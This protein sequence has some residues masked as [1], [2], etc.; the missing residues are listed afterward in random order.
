MSSCCATKRSSR[1]APSAD[2]EEWLS[3]R[4]VRLVV[5]DHRLTPVLRAAEVADAAVL[6]LTDRRRPRQSQCRPR[7]VR[8]QPDIRLVIRMFDQELGAHIPDLFPD[9]V[10]LSS[11]ALARR[12]SC[13]PP[14]MARPAAVSSWPAGCSASRRSADP[15]QARPFPCR[16]PGCTPTGPSRCSPTPAATEPDLILIDVA[17]EDAAIASPRPIPALRLDPPRRA[18]AAGGP[19]SGHAFA[20]PERRLVRFA[21][22]L[23]GLAIRLGD[24]LRR[25]SSISRRSMRSPMRSRS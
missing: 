25:R 3:D 15:P 24:L 18:R 9:A 8:A 12:G 14:S 22:I 13:R 17:E 2:H 16:S 1:S 4:G 6:V 5:G 21:A 19:A 11:S 20:T 7:R 10:A 23:L